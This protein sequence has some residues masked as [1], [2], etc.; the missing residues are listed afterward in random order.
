LEV[1]TMAAVDSELGSLTALV[2]RHGWPLARWHSLRARSARHLLAGRFAEAEELIG[3]ARDVL[4]G[5]QDE[6]A[7]G[8][9]HSVMMVLWQL[10]GDFDHPAFDRIIDNL[11]PFPVG[12]AR[13]AHYHL[14]A[15]DLDRAMTA[16]RAV[17]PQ[18]P[19]LPK[20]AAYLVILN[21]VSE[22]AITIGDRSAAQ[23][24]YELLLPYAMVYNNPI[25]G[26]A[27]S[28]SRL[29]GM[30]AAA[31][32][33]PVEAERHFVDAIAMERR[34]SALPF[35]ALAELEHAKFLVSQGARGGERAR[36]LLE[37]CLRT[38]RRL[39][40]APTVAAA[41]TLAEKLTTGPPLSRREREIALLVADGLSNRQIAER[42]V[43]SER[44]VE[45]HVRSMLAKLGLGNR[46]HVA[47]WVAR[48][49][50]G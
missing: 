13:H 10:T 27:G 4:T 21:G 12:Q 19:G 50:L 35:Q 25:Q 33:Q 15:G 5:T 46:T 17:R 20:N 34:I 42:F 16:Y 3:Q 38:A 26:V 18:V 37:S 8:L 49:G 14:A 9:Y 41:S 2:D 23:E 6:T 40:M 22:V 39:G 31:L 36:A 44:T 32:D 48:G 1:G 45:T 28:V 43:L 29:L 7:R 24:C 30:L 11:S 47:A